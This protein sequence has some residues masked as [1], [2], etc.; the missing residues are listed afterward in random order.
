MNRGYNVPQN[1]ILLFDKIR[2]INNDA[3][4]AFFSAIK[5]TLYVKDQ[6]Q[7]NNVAFNSNERRRVVTVGK[8]NNIM[9]I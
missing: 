8:T 6:Q 1:T 2:P 9:I 5:F 4:I 7:A 3:K